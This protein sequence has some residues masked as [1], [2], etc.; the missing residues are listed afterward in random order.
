MKARAEADTARRGLADRELKR[1][2]GGIRDIEFAVQL[3]QLVHGRHDES[4]RS[5]TTLDALEQLAIGG[6][7]ERTDASRLTDAYVFLRTV[8]HRLQLRDEQQTHTIPTDLGAHVRLARVLGY[9]DRPGGTAL[10]AFEA[11][12]RSHQGAV[13]AIHER[14]FFAPVL[15]TLAGAGTLAPELAEERLAAFGFA[16]AQHTRV[17]LRELTSG[18]SRTSRVM[19]QLLPVVLDW[20]STTP[21]PDLGLLQLRRL[22]ETAT[23]AGTLAATFRD[24]PGAAERLCRVLGASHVIGDAVLR[25]PD[26]V[27]VLADDAD[28]VANVRGRNSSTP[29][30]RPC[31][32]APTWRSDGR[33]SGA[34]S[35]ASCCASRRATSS[36]WHRSKSPRASSPRSPTRPSRRRCEPSKRRSRSP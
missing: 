2:R 17:A 9:R 26:F 36:G 13:R 16:D 19:Q 25:Q 23:R 22:T 3:L 14:L 33:G 12:Q 18:F 32:G 4:I 15:D 24:S 29:R 28:L 8:E 21:D 34:S 11:D 27:D 30:S 1:G 6:Y 35:G 5:A 7:V 31:C 20:L 10:E